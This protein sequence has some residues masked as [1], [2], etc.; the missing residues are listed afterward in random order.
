MKDVK[1]KYRKRTMSTEKI[2]ELYKKGKSTTELGRLADVSPRYIRM[3][4]N[5]HNVER[6]AHGSWK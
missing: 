6:R 4:L 2:I 3:L 5:D 1:P